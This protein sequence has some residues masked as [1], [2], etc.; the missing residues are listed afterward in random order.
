MTEMRQMQV[1]QLRGELLPVSMLIE[2]RDQTLQLIRDTL[3]P[4]YFAQ[5]K[6]RGLTDEEAKRGHDNMIRGLQN[7]YYEFSQRHRNG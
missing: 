2:L 5:L 4:A 6:N 3:G 1:N 7:I